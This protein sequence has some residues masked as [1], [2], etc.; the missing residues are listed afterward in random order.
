MSGK[1]VW[2]A[3]A[4]AKLLLGVLEQIKEAKL[5]LDSKKLAEFMGPNC[6][7]GAVC[8]RLAR[9]KKRGGADTA[10]TTTEDNEDQADG[11]SKGYTGDASDVSPQ[12]R[13]ATRKPR[14]SVKKAKAEPKAEAEADA[15]G[16]VKS[17]GGV[18]EEAEDEDE[19]M[20]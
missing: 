3:E 12:K 1:M 18:K 15:K 13:K 6:I 9:L 16:N 14:V 11:T 20:A 17:E 2:N 19:D 8:N 7:P 4:D 5:S 10:T